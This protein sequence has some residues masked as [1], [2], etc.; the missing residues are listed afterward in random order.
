MC[1][2][3]LAN[4]LYSWAK[5]DLTCTLGGT[6]FR[7]FRRFLK[8]PASAEVTNFEIECS[9]NDYLAVIVK[10]YVAWRI[11]PHE[12]NKAIRSLDF[13]N[14]QNPLKKTSDLIADMTKDAVRRSIAEISISNILKSSEQLKKSIEGILKDVATWGLVVDTIGINKIF[15]KSENVY[16]NLQSAHRDQLRLQAELSSQQTESHIEQ[17]QLEHEKERKVRESDLQETDTREKLKQK[18]LTEESQIEEMRMLKKKEREEL[19][20]SSE[21]RETEIREKL[22]QKQMLQQSELEEMRMLKQKEREEISLAQEIE[23]SRYDCEKAR[24]L[25]D[26]ELQAI[27]ISMDMKNLDVQ[28]RRRTVES[29][30]TDREFAELITQ[31]LAGLG[32]LYKSSNITV[33]GSEKEAMSSML[34]PLHATIEFV[35]SLLSSSNVPKPSV[36]PESKKN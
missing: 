8:V 24:M 5:K 6:A 28:E 23:S 30:L 17:S 31:K 22:K 3:C 35:K 36:T 18:Q 16:N 4:I 19:T 11:N 12:V 13:Y 9:T 21:L 10:G 20:L 26:Q 2:L 25:H 7:L 33:I 1:A 29:G 15:I 32:S 34:A 14:I 27:R